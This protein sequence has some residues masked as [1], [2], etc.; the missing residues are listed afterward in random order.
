MHIPD[1]IITIEQA[2]IYL[3]LSAII[4]IYSLRNIQRTL[5]DKH[6]PLLGLL[7][8]GLLAAQ[9]FNFPIPGGTSGHLVGTTLATALVGPFGAIIVLA[10]VLLIQA[11]FGDGG[12]LAYGANLLSMG[13]IPA[14]V[15]YYAIRYIYKLL[16]NT[17]PR[18]SRA[19]AVGITGFVATIASA[20]IAS[21]E[22][23]LAGLEPI[24]LIIGWMLSLHALIGFGEAII[25]W[26]II[27]YV[28]TIR[29]DLIYLP[30]FEFQRMKTYHQSISTNDHRDI[31]INKRGILVS[32]IIVFGIM[33]IYGLMASIN[34]DGLEKTLEQIGAESS[35]SSGLISFGETYT[36]DLI[37]LAIGMISVFII[38]VILIVIVKKGFNNSK[39]SGKSYHGSILPFRKRSVAHTRISPTVKLTVMLLL[40]IFILINGSYHS[41]VFLVLLGLTLAKLM[42][43][44]FFEVIDHAIHILPLLIIL[45]AWIPFFT[46]HFQKTGAYQETSGKNDSCA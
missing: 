28:V 15:S 33:S 34:P 32:A 3:L 11:M 44:R 19:L 25:S 14:I 10:T 8:A 9:M 6:I 20:F 37:T 41:M 17:N 40:V 7:G 45:F 31:N 23:I 27:Q 22:L 43:S 46:E 26:A 5:G 21:M 18:R 13:V 38:I 16:D 35:A 36:G 30:S 29:S 42:H 1:G 39:T 2:V 24:S 4:V 12:I